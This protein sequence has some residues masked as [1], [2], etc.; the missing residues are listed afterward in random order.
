MFEI[1]KDSFYDLLLSRCA[2]RPEP[3][4]DVQRIRVRSG[5][6]EH[7][8]ADQKDA[9]QKDEKELEIGWEPYLATKSLAGAVHLAATLERPLLLQG[10]PGC[11]KTMLAHA[12]AYA[13]GLPLEE[14]HVK[15]TSIAKD[16]LYT[17]DAVSRLYDVQL[18][19]DGP[20][21]GEEPRCKTPARYVHSEPLGQA[22]IRAT[23]GQRSVVLIDEI[24]KADLDF[25]NDLLL[26]LDRR[27]FEVPEARALSVD[28]GKF[29]ESCPIVIITHNE[30]KPLPAAF[31]RRCIFHYVRFP[32]DTD[33]LKKILKL[34]APDSGTFDEH[35]LD[36]TIEVLG[37]LEKLDLRKK[38][39]LS[40]LIDWVKYL[41]DCQHVPEDLDSLPAIGA[42]LKNQSDQQLAGREFNTDG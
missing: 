25:P 21:D 35:L 29:S 23:R 37:R 16:L 10:E 42:L 31:L 17:Y 34:H 13:L 40:E 30:E 41:T 8:S 4:V 28:A 32:E 7:E 11:G 12:V 5:R 33:T 3:G 18:G 36:K 2:T 9:A 26:E 39:G 15:S 1:D 38:L 27:K 14:C 24:D 19:Q 20:H 6:F 22:F